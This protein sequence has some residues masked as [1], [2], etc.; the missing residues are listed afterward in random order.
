MLVTKGSGK[1]TT[2][3][4]SS[5][6]QNKE[7]KVFR[8][9]TV[10]LSNK[11]DYAGNLPL[12][13]R[14][15]FYHI[16]QCAEKCG[17]CKRR[18]H[19]A[20]D[21]RILVLKERKRSVVSGKKAEVI[22]YGCG[23]LGH[24]KR[25]CLIVKFQNRVDM[26]W[27]GKAR[28]DSSATTSNI[29]SNESTYYLVKLKWSYLRHL[30]PVLAKVGAIAYKLQLP[31][32]L[33]GA[34]HMF[35]VSNL[36]KCFAD[37]QL[38]IPLDGL[39]IDDK[40]HFVEEPLEI[41]DHEDMAAPTIPVSAEDN[42]RD[43]ID[44]RVDII[45]PEPVAAV[46]FHVA[47]VVRTQAQHGEAI[48]GIHEYLQGVPIEAENA[49]LRGKANVVT[50]DLS[51]KERI[52][53]L[54]VRALVM[55]IGLDL[56]KQILNAQ[57]GAQKPE[58]L[59]HEDVGVKVSNIPCDS[60]ID[61]DSEHEANDDMGYDPSDLTD[62]ESSNDMDEVAEV[63]RIDTNV[64]NF[65]TPMCKA[66]KEFNYLL[67]IDPDLL[68]KDIEG[69]KTYEYYKD[70]W[71]YEWNKDVPWVDEKPWTN[72]GVWSKPTPVKHT[73]KPFNYKTRCLEWPTCSW[74]NDGYC[75]GGNF[76]GTYIIGNQLHYQNHEWYEALEDSELKDEAL[77]NKAIMDGFIKDD[78]DDDESRYEQMRRWNIYT[79]YDDA[80]EINHEDNKREELCEDHEI[81]VCNI[82][83]YM[84]INY[85]FNNN[86]EY[87][88]VKED[89][90][91]DFTITRE[92]AC[93]AYQE[94]FR[95]MDEGWMVT[96]AE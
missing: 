66:F 62:E 83:R 80:Y 15:N 89:E 32:E 57:T 3:R 88:A 40:I 35:H 78:D 39:H 65:E 74:F 4:S 64:F 55:T 69:F 38:T 13:N 1:V 71:I 91:N 96:R 31:Q 23:G 42:L 54:R 27:K 58:N 21:C 6:Q 19:Q 18:G 60:K 92:E 5:K 48:R 63:F 43:P 72:A 20:R 2:S 84:M 26:Y 52:K 85:S 76:L 24:Y 9:H 8:A 82:R 11:E 47:A 34:Q 16:G 67:Q 7:H 70:D 10:R 22:C 49:S 73:C 79:N 77:R 86:E 75:N 50:D 45:C 56:P 51:R 36:K 25:N 29:T 93:R 95:I 28:E 14:C 17:N 12:C 59:K 41:M 90:Y 46:A 33:S 87:V 30:F 81:P 44:I 53:P 68:T 37:E 61:D 94:I